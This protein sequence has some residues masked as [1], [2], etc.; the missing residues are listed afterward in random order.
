MKGMLIK[1][2][3]MTCPAWLFGI[4]KMQRVCAGCRMSLK[5]KGR[6]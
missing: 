6:M 4:K 5:A 2:H 1:I 3:D